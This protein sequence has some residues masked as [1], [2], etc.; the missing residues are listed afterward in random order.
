MK[1]L[2]MLG[3]LTLAVACVPE[4]T[5]P[6]VLKAASA[7]QAINVV[8]ALLDAAKASD[9]G[10]LAA[11]MCGAREDTQERAKAALAGPLRIQGYDLT[12]VEPAWVGAEPYFRIDVTLQKASEA[13]RRSLSVRA[14]E[15]CVDRLLGEPVEG[16]KRPDPAEISL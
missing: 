1:H 3:A 16:A 12:R 2:G 8:R 6:P 10:R 15:G 9:A 13:D 4:S 7:E 11:H 5:A 14:R